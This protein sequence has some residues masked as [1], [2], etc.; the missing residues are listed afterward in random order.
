MIR[1]ALKLAAVNALRGVLLKFVVP[2]AAVLVLVG[3]LIGGVVAAIFGGTGSAAHAGDCFASGTGGKG[4]AVHASQ[5]EVARAIDEGVRE[6]GFSG[7]ASRIAIIAAYG[8]SSLENINYGDGAVNPDGSI[9]S[10]IGIFQQQNSWGSREERMNPKIAAQLFI[11]G[12]KRGG[13]GLADVPGWSGMSETAAIHAV[14][15]NADPNHYAR[16]VAPADAVIKE[17]GIDVSRSGKTSNDGE[18]KA[19][20]S[21]A[22]Q[23]ASS[24]CGTGA[25]GGNAQAGDTYPWISRTPGPGVYV[26][27]GLGFYF[28]EC[29]SY[30]G[31]KLNELAGASGDD[32]TNWPIGNNKGGNGSHLGN[33]AEW[34]DAWVARG[35]RVSTTPVANS[36]AW[37]GAYGGSGIGEAGH[38]AWVDA[39]QEDG[40]VVLSEYNNPSLAPP[41][42]RYSKRPAS[43][44]T[45][46][47]YLVPPDEFIKTAPKPEEKKEDEK[48][49]E[50][51][52]APE[53]SGEEPSHEEQP[54]P[55][56]EERT[57]RRW[58]GG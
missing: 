8:E 25:P 43:V 42:H 15:K 27:D 57:S 32:P 22:A 50:E 30:I 23:S 35:W 29:T 5:V 38:V 21:G 14:Q 4:T 44:S 49:D 56:A 2:V 17:A 52:P 11:L 55:P 47:A 41:G 45:A 39:V 16:S 53:T 19:Q 58:S 12:P 34:R 13:G 33:A 40:R 6:L 51:R 54:A 7:Q 10:S 37:W 48:T 31:W 9:A 24:G 18:T 26:E 28:G 3:G 46:Q 36:V 1:E 20:G